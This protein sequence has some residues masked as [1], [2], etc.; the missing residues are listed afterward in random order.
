MRESQGIDA[1]QIWGGCVTLSVLIFL[2]P[3]GPAMAVFAPRNTI[4]THLEQAPRIVI[5]A[6]E[7]PD[8]DAVG[9]A[10]GLWHLLR[11]AGRPA[12]VAG[13]EGARPRLR[14]LPGLAQN[15]AA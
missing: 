8:G 10:L 4:V 2:L 5:T 13:L 11:A 15:V 1:G 7:K 3:K 6:H 14:F 12:V 9:A